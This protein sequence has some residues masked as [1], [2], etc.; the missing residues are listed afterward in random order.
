[1]F[2]AN[3]V[4]EHCAKLCK[5]KNYFH[6]AKAYCESQNSVLATIYDEFSQAKAFSML[7]DPTENPLSATPVGK[8]AWIGMRRK[9]V[10]AAASVYQWISLW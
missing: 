1:M 5:T 2:C 7:S 9:T 10:S 4:E 3:H 6:R 8:V